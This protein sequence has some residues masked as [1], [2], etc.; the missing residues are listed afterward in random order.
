MR[1]VMWFSVGFF[2]AVLVGAYCLSADHYLAAAGVSAVLLAAALIIAMRFPAVR[3]AAMV[4][5]ACTLGFCWMH[6]FDAIKLSTARAADD[7]QMPITVSAIDYS[8]LTDYGAAVEGTVSIN[9]KTYRVIAY[10]DQELSLKPGDL[11]HGEFLLRCTLAGASGESANHRSNKIYLTA[12]PRGELTVE[13][14]EKT[15]WYCYPAV[16]R[17]A[18]LDVIQRSFPTDTASFACAPPMSQVSS[19][20]TILIIC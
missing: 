11:L 17:R 6:G 16:I 3:I 7:L 4:F 2:L 9:G 15:P 1:R 12:R 18:M 19:S 14:C 13:V 8:Y 5:F 20:R 10:H